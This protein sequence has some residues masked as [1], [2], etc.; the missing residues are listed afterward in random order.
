MSNVIN[1]NK[2]PVPVPCEC[3]DGTGYR[4]SAEILPHPEPTS[5]HPFPWA[6]VLTTANDCR[7]RVQTSHTEYVDIHISQTQALDMIASLATHVRR[8]AV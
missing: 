4:L 2:P 5:S 8:R 3:S 1:F 7:I 6:R